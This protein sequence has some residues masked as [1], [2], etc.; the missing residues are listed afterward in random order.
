MAARTVHLADKH[1]SNLVYVLG[2]LDYWVWI[3][4]EAVRA[5]M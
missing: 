3:D 1:A 2:Q 4:A 5:K